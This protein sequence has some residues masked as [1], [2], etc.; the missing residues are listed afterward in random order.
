MFKFLVWICFNKGISL[1]GD[2]MG[3]IQNGIFLA[4]KGLV[5]VVLGSKCGQHLFIFWRQLD[6]LTN[7]YV[8][9]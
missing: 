8:S 1:F 7:I 3:C 4:A 6:K 2:G 9:N 5:L